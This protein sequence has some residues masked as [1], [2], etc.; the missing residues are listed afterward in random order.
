M[1]VQYGMKVTSSG[2]DLIWVCWSLK[3]LVTCSYISPYNQGVGQRGMGGVHVHKCILALCLFV[4]CFVS[5]NA[6]FEPDGS[7][8]LYCRHSLFVARYCRLK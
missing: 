1:I 2:S 3:Q 4:F 8:S 6:W 5:R 7:F